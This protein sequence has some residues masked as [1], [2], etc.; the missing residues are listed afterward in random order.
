MTLSRLPMSHLMSHLT[1]GSLQGGCHELFPASL[2]YPKFPEYINEP[3]KERLMRWLI[4]R[5]LIRRNFE[6]PPW[7]GGNFFMK[8]LTL[9][10]EANWFKSLYFSSRVRPV[11]EEE[12]LAEST[13]D[14]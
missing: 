11:V 7:R 14:E 12:D 3:C 10:P 6:M 1:R 5:W 2:E 4:G 9:P 8:G 13:D